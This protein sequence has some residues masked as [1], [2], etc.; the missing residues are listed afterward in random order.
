MDKIFR[1]IGMDRADATLPDASSYW[2]RRQ[3]KETV[4]VVGR[5][6]R[7]VRK[8][9]AV[10]AAE[11]DDVW[12]RGEIGAALAFAR[13]MAPKSCILVAPL[14]GTPV[15]APGDR[16]EARDRVPIGAA[17]AADL[18]GWYRTEGGYQAEIDTISVSLSTSV[19]P[20]EIL[21]QAAWRAA[22][23]YSMTDAE[24]DAVAA[25]F[26]ESKDAQGSIQHEHWSLRDLEAVCRVSSV[27]DWAAILFMKWYG[28]W[29]LTASVRT[30]RPMD[31]LFDKIASGRMGRRR[32]R[33][34]PNLDANA[35]Y[36][37]RLRAL[38]DQLP[39]PAGLN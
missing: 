11:P 16:R 30:L 26:L 9:F 31:K 27:S 5:S 32:R 21:L 28:I 3:G 4:S 14:L 15:E 7:P 37:V 6:E 10:L 2:I 1:D 8:G 38:L 34:D 20:G 35:D 18:N 23:A 33:K 25:S 29:G 19:K 22:E 24:L 36:R 17:E 39:A 13:R 12:D